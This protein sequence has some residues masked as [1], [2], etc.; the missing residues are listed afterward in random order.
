MTL[1]FAMVSLYMT[2]K[3]YITNAKIHKWD[4]VNLKNCIKGHHQQSEKPSHAMIE[5]NYKSYI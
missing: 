3:V 5:S 1:D 4:Y 2:P